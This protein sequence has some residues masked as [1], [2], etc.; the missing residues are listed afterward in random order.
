[1]KSILIVNKLYF[2]DIGGVESVAKQYGEWLVNDKHN[3]TVL[4]AN[5]SSFS[6]T[7]IEF[8]NGIEV[9]RCS[10][11]ANIYSMPLSFSLVYKFIKIY[12]NFDIIHFHEPYPIGTFLSLFCSSKVKVFVTWHCDIIKQKGLIK[13]VVYY[14]QNRLLQ[15]ASIITTT[16]SNLLKSSTQL[17]KVISKVKVI[18]LSVKGYTKKK[19]FEGYYLVLGRISYYKGLDILIKSLNHLSTIKRKVLIVGKGEPDIEQFILKNTHKNNNIEFINEYVNEAIKREYIENC[20]CLLFPSTENSEA[21]GI[22][23]L[24]AM[25][26]GKPIINTLLDTAVPWVSLDEITGYTAIPKSIESLS[27]KIN[28]IDSLDI[29]EYNNLCNNSFKRFENNF[30]DKQVCSKVKNLFNK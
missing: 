13:N 17:T 20:Y 3:V 9:I 23:Q 29:N 8:I 4:T 11:I 7:K 14:L 19:C 24:E 6:A 12:K 25:S 1:M 15:K 18:P 22:V 10:S 26:S 5:P 30:S 27:D 2:P 21:F 28:K 16:S